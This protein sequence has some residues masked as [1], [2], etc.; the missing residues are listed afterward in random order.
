MYHISQMYDERGGC[1]VLFTK[2]AGVSSVLIFVVAVSADNFYRSNC[3]TPFDNTLAISLC[4]LSSS[5]ESMH[6]GS[7]QKGDNRMGIES[8]WVAVWIAATT[9]S[10]FRQLKN[11]CI[12]VSMFA[13]TP[14]FVAA[15]RTNVEIELWR[16]QMASTSLSTNRQW[17]CGHSQPHDPK[18]SNL[19]GMIQKNDKNNKY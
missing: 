1:A 15:V 2:H 13:I 8:Q 5:A 17:P 10:H 19:S 9:R 16:R 14:A 3:H 12:Q 7:A 6:S 4:Q 18:Q 11:T